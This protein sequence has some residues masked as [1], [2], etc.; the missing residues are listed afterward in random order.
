MGG[1]KYYTTLP[2]AMIARLCN[3]VATS[4][5]DMKDKPL[6]IK[7]ELDLWVEKTIEDLLTK[8][9]FKVISIQKLV[10]IQVALH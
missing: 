6:E 7:G 10:K 8:T 1:N 5:P 9:N 4:F 3:E 2:V